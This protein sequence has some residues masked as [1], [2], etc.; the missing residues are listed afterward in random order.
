MVLTENKP[1]FKVGEHVSS[2]Y[3]KGHIFKLDSR[4]IH[5]VKMYEFTGVGYPA[6]FMG[7][8][9]SNLTLCDNTTK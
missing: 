1:P 8:H 2:L 5:T 9:E 7:I 4:G 3:G 6:M